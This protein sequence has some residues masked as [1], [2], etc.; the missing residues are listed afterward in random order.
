MES[1]RPLRKAAF[2]DVLDYGV[3][4]F[5]KHFRKILLLNLM[6]NLP[7]M[8]LIA[9][10]N[11]MLTSQYLGFFNPA[12][13]TF[14]DPTDIVSSIFTL[15][16]MMFVTL[17]LYGLHGLTLSN[18][19]E[20][21]IIKLIYADAVLKQERTL[22]QV[23]R[24]CFGQ[25]G[26]MLLG[27][28]LF[29]LIQAAVFFAVY[30]IIVIGA[31]GGT[32]A[33]MGITA[34]SL[35]TPWASVVLTILCVLACVALLLF[36]LIMICFFIG[37]YWMFLPAVCIEQQKAGSSIGRCGNLGKNSFFLISLAYAG[38]GLLVGLFPGV[39][40]ISFGLASAI[41]GNV[42][43][44]LI[45]IGTVVTQ[46]FSAVLQPL[47]TCILAALYITLRVKREGLDMEMA[48]WEIK[49]EEFDRT[50]RWVTEAPNV[51]E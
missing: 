46:V 43:V 25:F 32:F 15:Y 22:K 36:I 12:A 40:N 49:K 27:K 34:V 10:L 51:T 11:P 30:I 16:A 7:V 48:L 4:F 13:N 37:R 45:Q 24:E 44:T 1:L 29:G 5:R 6:F 42:D 20:G 2:T 31:F 8:L 47:L 21:S 9:I 14:S 19:M 35:S 23:I 41:S 3:Y 38:G 17:A 50:Q 39:V 33:F 26:S 18:M 28:I